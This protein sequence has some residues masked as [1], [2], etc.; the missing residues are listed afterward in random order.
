MFKIATVVLVALFSFS[1]PQSQSD[2]IAALKRELEKMRAQQDALKADVEAIKSLLEALTGRPLGASIVNASLAIAGEPSKGSK[3]AKVTMVEISDYHCP[4]CRR[5][6][7]QTQ[8][9]LD[10]E[11]ISTG[12]LQYVFVDYPIEQLHPEAYK[13]H[14]AANCA[15][16][17]GKYW[18]MHNQLFASPTREVAELEKQ[19]SGLGL[20]AGKFKAC[21][22]GGKY[23][24]P[25]RESV[26]RMQELG[27]D[28]TPTFLIGLTPAGNQPFKVIKVLRGAM[29][30]A[31]FK[32]IIDD[33]ATR[34]Q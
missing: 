33:V 3:A 24:K 16:D 26:A 12:K 21:L 1:G 32:S 27:V 20:D 23:A 11:Y 25:V 10:A 4:Y 15:G 18:E 8:P 28:S 5:H 13:A 17:Q 34:T 29:P 9:Q 30:F 14:E 19:A 22:E 6:M 2:E 7:Q 31:Q